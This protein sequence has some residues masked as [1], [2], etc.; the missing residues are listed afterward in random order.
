M[1]RVGPLIVLTIEFQHASNPTITN[2]IGSLFG[3]PRVCKFRVCLVERT[4]LCTHEM[5]IPFHLL[6]HMGPLPVYRFKIL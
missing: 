1:P 2:I 5:G 4:S 3:I 6:S